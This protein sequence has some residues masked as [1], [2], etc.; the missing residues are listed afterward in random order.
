MGLGLMIVRR[1]VGDN[2][3]KILFEHAKDLG[4]AKV[5]LCLKPS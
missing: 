2:V 1:V 3:G 5:K 4:G